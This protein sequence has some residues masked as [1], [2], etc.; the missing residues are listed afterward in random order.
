MKKTIAMIAIAILSACC[1]FTACNDSKIADNTEH[2]D[3]ITKTLKLSKEY[4]GKKLMSDDG[5]GAAKLI[6]STTDGD[7]TTFSL[8]EGG[9]VT[10]RYQG[11]DT[12]ESTGGVEKWGK[13]ASKFTDE[14][15]KSATEIVLESASGGIPEKDSKGNRSLCYVW[16]KTE[17]DDFKLLNL[18]LVENGYSLCKENAEKAYYSYFM[19]A[20]AFAQSI[21]LRLFSKLDDPLFDTAVQSLSLKAFNESPDSYQENTKVQLYAFV[22]GETTSSSNA[23]TYKITQYDEETGNEYSISLYAGYNTTGMLRIGD[24]YFILGTLQKHSG[25]WQISGVTVDNDAKGSDKKSWRSESSY[26]LIFDSSSSLFTAK[27]NWNCLGNL[28]VKSVD[29]D[30]SDYTFVGS[31]ERYNG[32]TAE[33]TFKVSVPSGATKLIKAGDVLTV[34]RCYQ[35]EAGSNVFT[36]VDYSDVGFVS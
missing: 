24:L 23:T 36:I 27:V 29:V 14:R 2:F 11:V 19:K 9:S 34:S 16:Y 18:E 17:S 20:E 26:R 12:P 28:T 5:I 10:V 22:T 4:E 31:A 30:G 35:F 21:E 25:N 15:L 33:F 3:K 8:V 32:E 1:L 6:G 13:A 7:T